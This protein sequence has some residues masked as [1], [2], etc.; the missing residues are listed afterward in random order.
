[1]N[2]LPVS[3]EAFWDIHFTTLDPERS[4]LFIMQKV[5]NYGPWEGQ[6]ALLRYYGAERI[7]Q[8]IAH[9]TYLREPVISFFYV[10]CYSYKKQILNAIQRTSHTR[11]LGLIKKAVSRASIADFGFIKV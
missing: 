11:Y 5:F 7:K 9:A 6:I 2:G 1:M 10:L 8:E 4:A 3:K